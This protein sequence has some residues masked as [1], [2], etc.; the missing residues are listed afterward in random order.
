MTAQT[1]V[2]LLEAELT[3]SRAVAETLDVQRRALLAPEPS[4]LEE[5]SDRL[6]DEF[7]HLSALLQMRQAA[8]DSE[9]EPNTRA[10]AL[11]REVRL[12]QARIAGLAGLNQ[13]LL[14]DRLAY[15]SAILGALTPGAAPCAYGAGEPPRPAPT[16]IARSA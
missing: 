3:A 7:E 8:C 10:A 11:L 13:E 12:T 15:V 4:V 16:A 14:A 2:S 1:L 6:A 5:I 9:P